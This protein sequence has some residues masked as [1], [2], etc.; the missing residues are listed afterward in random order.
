ML[1]HLK[2]IVGICHCS[3]P[4]LF[5]ENGL[6]GLTPEIKIRQNT[7]LFERLEAL[8]NRSCHLVR[9]VPQLIAA[10]SLVG[11]DDSEEDSRL[12][13][14]IL[15]KS[16]PQTH[17]IGAKRLLDLFYSLVE[18]RLFCKRPGAVHVHGLIIARL[19]DRCTFLNSVW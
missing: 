19:E 3:S 12:P 13:S 16:V 2:Q 4:G 14:P 8:V 17:D 9:G 11:K 18:L 10:T 15:T 7:P 1:S 5:L 6:L